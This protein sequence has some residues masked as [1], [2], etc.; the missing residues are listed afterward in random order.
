MLN[1]TFQVFAAGGVIFHQRAQDPFLLLANFNEAGELG[2]DALGRFTIDQ[3]RINTMQRRGPDQG[4]HFGAAGLFHNAGADQFEP[5]LGFRRVP[6]KAAVV[7][8]DVAERG[9][10]LRG[11]VGLQVHKARFPQ[12]VAGQLGQAAGRFVDPAHAVP[13]QLHRHPAQPFRAADAG[14]KVLGRLGKRHAL[15]GSLVDNEKALA[16]LAGAAAVGVLGVFTG[17]RLR[18]KVRFCGRGGCH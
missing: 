12:R 9:Q 1:R 17:G 7:H 4:H 11:V 10:L 14:A 6:R 15:S 16:V 2:Q 3:R 5:G 8:L 18:G 13:V